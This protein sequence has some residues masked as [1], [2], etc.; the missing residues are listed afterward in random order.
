VIFLGLTSDYSIKESYNTY[1]KDLRKN[2]QVIFFYQLYKHFYKIL[3]P[4]RLHS[5]EHEIVVV[6]K[7]IL[8]KEPT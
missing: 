3:I 6:N 2:V 5:V 1:V 8:R 7:T 4:K